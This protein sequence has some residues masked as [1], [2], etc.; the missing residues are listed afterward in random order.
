MIA[1]VRFPKVGD[2]V[3]MKCRYNKTLH[4]GLLTDQF[5]RGGDPYPSFSVEWFKNE[6]RPFNHEAGLYSINLLNC[7]NEYTLFRNGEVV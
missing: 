2:I 4:V 1:A 6:P 3:H 5:N 7:T